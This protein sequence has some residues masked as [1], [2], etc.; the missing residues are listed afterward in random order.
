VRGS[1]AP[2]GF[3]HDA[4]SRS[5]ANTETL[6]NGFQGVPTASQRANFLAL[7]FGQ[8]PP[9]SPGDLFDPCVGVA[10]A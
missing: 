3:I 4:V 6:C 8:R 2:R 7:G 1:F 10:A 9:A 5:S